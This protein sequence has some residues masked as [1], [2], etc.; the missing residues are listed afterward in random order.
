MKNV[1]VNKISKK[2]STFYALRF[3][4]FLAIATIVAIPVFASA[5]GMIPCGGEGE[6]AC[7]FNDFIKVIGNIVNGVIIIISVYAAI[8]FM[9]AGYAYLTS[10]GSEEK[11]SYAKGI[12]WKVFLGYII[13]LGAWAFVYM[14]ETQLKVNPNVP[15]KDV[16]SD[17]G[18]GTFLNNQPTP[19]P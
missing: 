11:V 5:A 10:G 13:I 12:F 9:Y 8:S 14:I 6:A 16:P 3:A 19:A 1:T 4:V 7:T 2:R 18:G 17:Q 15:I